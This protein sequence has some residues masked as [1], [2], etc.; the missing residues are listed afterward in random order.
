MSWKRQANAFISYLQPQ[1]HSC[2]EKLVQYQH[3]PWQLES[4]CF[5][6][7]LTLLVWLGTWWSEAA[8]LS[9]ETTSKSF[10]SGLIIENFVLW[11]CQ[12]TTKITL[13]NH[14]G[15]HRVCQQLTLLTD[16]PALSQHCMHG[17]MCHCSSK[18]YTLFYKD[19]VN[20]IWLKT[21]FSVS[22]KIIDLTCLFC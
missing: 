15:P 9:A 3:I 11:F 17:C 19:E 8:C 22:N 18:T 10:C 2:L 14:P 5:L 16:N 21:F 12:S 1:A 6:Q 20:W 13:E 7:H 4:S